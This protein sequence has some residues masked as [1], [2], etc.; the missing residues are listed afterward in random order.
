MPACLAANQLTGT[1]EPSVCGCEGVRGILA[2]FCMGAAAVCFSLLEAE[3]PGLVPLLC[4]PD[5][6]QVH[7]SLCSYR[8]GDP[9]FFYILFTC[10]FKIIRIYFDTVYII[11]LSV[12]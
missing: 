4:G 7:E 9:S 5:C 8:R 2:R 10:C 3:G 12:S 11:I 1:A 6:N